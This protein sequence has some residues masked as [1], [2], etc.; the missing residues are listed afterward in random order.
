MFRKKVF[1]CAICVFLLMG[2]THASEEKVITDLTIKAKIV[3]TI[4]RTITLLTNL[5]KNTN[6]G[7][8]GWANS[9]TLGT[10]ISKLKDSIK[11]IK[12]VNI[13]KMKKYTK[14]IKSYFSDYIIEDL[15]KKGLREYKTIMSQQ[16]NLM[17]RAMH[18]IEAQVR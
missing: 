16:K 7:D 2:V 13:D 5:D 14:K 3:K 17:V 10:A 12:T 9:L 18:S 6:Y 15:N 11:D 1:S 8:L 4:D